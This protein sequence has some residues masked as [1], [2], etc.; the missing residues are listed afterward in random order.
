MLSIPIP[1]VAVDRERWWA[2]LANTDAE[3]ESWVSADNPDWLI[4]DRNPNE[5]NSQLV[6]TLNLDPQAFIDRF[7]GWTWG[8]PVIQ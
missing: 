1:V 2:R 7:L 4:Q 3:G 8:K 5:L 6:D